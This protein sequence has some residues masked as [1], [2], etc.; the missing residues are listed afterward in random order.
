MMRKSLFLFATLGLLC[1]PILADPVI[2]DFENVTIDPSTSLVWVDSW[3]Q[4][5]FVLTATPAENS[6][7]AGPD[8]GTNPRGSN[9]FTWRDRAV[10]IELT[11]VHESGLPFNFLSLVYGARR[12]IPRPIQITG[13]L[14]D[15][16]TITQV[17]PGF[18]TWAQHDVFHDPTK[19]YDLEK[20]VIRMADPPPGP[21]ERPPYPGIDDLEVCLSQVPEPSTLLLLSGGL[22]LVALFRKRC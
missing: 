20:V 4:H 14:V 19:T 3:E 21:D 10:T 13:H 1:T 12:G 17:V 15:G 8:G 18:D 5:G 11:L 7:V 9:L 22:G 16:G 2:I 6:A